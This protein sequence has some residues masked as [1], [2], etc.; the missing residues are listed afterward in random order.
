M[1]KMFSLVLALF[2]FCGVSAR[3]LAAD[4]PVE[5]SF[6]NFS[7]TEDAMKSIY[8]V[9]EDFEK[10]NPGIKVKN[11]PIGVG[12]I[13]SQLIVMIMGGNAPDVAQLY[14]GDAVVVY[15]MGALYSAEELYDQKFLDNLPPQ[16]FDI[17]KW[18]DKH[19][20]VVFSPNPMTFFYNKKL[21]DRLGYKEPPKTL[22]EMEAMMKKGKAEIKDLIGF[23]SDTTVRTLGFNHQW[24]FMNCFEYLP[25]QGNVSKLNSP[26]M[27]K[28]GEW[29]RRMVKE[30]YTLPGKRFGEF[31]PMAAQGR[32]LFAIDNAQHRGLMK[33]FKK[34]MT[35]QEYAETWIPAP[36]PMGPSGRSA[37]SPDAQS[38]VVLKSTKHK[39][40]AAKF[41]EYLTASKSALTKYQD[42]A[43]FLPPVKNYQELAP[44][45]FADPGRQG[46]MKY[47]VPNTL[48]MPFG[49]NYA[50]LALLI[51][52]SMQE[53]I[54]SDKPVQQ[55][56]DSYQPKIEG[57]IQ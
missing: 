18:G 57:I 7:T 46:T 48:G 43:G 19:S 27:V 56:L 52:T 41:V 8:K 3:A 36:F 22:D 24:N 21:L 25:I 31:R 53:V 13:R 38:L 55:I 50:K 9:M 23:Q 49:P 14:V 51:M 10:E 15:T 4:A 29:M 54:T 39:E 35:D 12:D 6:L 2:M 1:R 16:F 47:A 11:M 5:I 40:A 44:G 28:F 32:L 30:G 34:D 42:P 33:A 20:G 37:S 45:S 26:N 17:G